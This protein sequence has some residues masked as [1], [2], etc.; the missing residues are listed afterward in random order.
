ME[1]CGN[2]ERKGNKK[3]NRSATAHAEAL[4]YFDQRLQAVLDAMDDNNLL[5]DT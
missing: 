1:V 2:V 3:E 4:I 5:I